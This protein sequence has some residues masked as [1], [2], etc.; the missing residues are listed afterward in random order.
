MM[1]KTFVDLIK[2]KKEKKELSSEEIEKLVTGIATGEMADYQASAWLMAAYLN[3]LSRKETFSLTQSIRNS[4]ERLEWSSLKK[5]FPNCAIADKH[6]TGGVGDKV[7]LIL[8]P[9]AVELDLIVP[10]M[11]GRG[12]GHTG[13]TVD[14]LLTIPGFKM[15]FSPLERESILK[16]EKACML[17]QTENLCPAD[18]KLYHLRDVTSTIDNIS[19]ITASIVSKKSAEGAENIIYDVKFGEGAFMQE[20]ANANA[21]AQSLVR[22]SQDLGLKA[23]ACLTRMNEPLGVMVGNSLE[24][25]E[26]L[27][28]LKNSYPTPLHQKISSPLKQL[29]CEL[30]AH[31]AM[32]SGTRKDFKSTVSEC[33]KLI[34]SG[35]AYENFIKLCRS[36]GAV[37]NFETSFPQSQQVYEFKAHSDGYVKN[38]HALLLGQLGVS[39]GVGRKKKEDP[40]VAELGFEL[41]AH[42]GQKVLQ[43]ETLMKV[44]LNDPLTWKKV[45]QALSEIV[46]LSDDKVEEEKALLESICDMNP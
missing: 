17:S 20:F 9:L 45:Q 16:S 32:I 25:I 1:E 36:Q 19:L 44:H 26:S 3:G 43:G 24:V 35:K 10:M 18:K 11:S 33:F 27:W 12:L 40:I 14:K 7:S 41:L 5:Q 38:I 22:V 15:D 39:I 42:R 30:A 37:Q 31:M 2:I 8:V 46:I 23:R 21:L 6:S 29:C 28:I 34:E 13:G 4:G